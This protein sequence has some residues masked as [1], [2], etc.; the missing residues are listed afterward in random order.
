MTT[1]NALNVDALQ[2]DFDAT[3]DHEQRVEP[4]DW[5]PDGYRKTLIRQIAQHAHSE[6]IGMQPEGNWLTRAPSLRRKAI[7]MAKVQDEA[8]HGLYLYSAAETLGA[9]R[10]DL[11]VK[12]IEGK[13]K[14]S[15]IFNYPTLTYAD[16][17]TIGWLVDG[18]AICN[19]VPLCRSS[20]GPYA[21]A[22]IRVCKE[23]SFHQRQGYELLST[24]MRGTD[25]QRAMVQESVN[26]W[27]WPALM[28]FGP[29]DDESPNTEQSMKWGIKRHTNDELRQRFVDMSIPQA[30]ALGVTFPDPDL[31]WNEERKSHDFGEPDWSEFMQVIKGN[32]ASNIER[33]ANRR[34]A[35]ENGAWVRDAA[36]AFAARNAS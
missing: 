24:M 23:E 7:L 13:Q 17:G 18:A 34:A 30:E 2:E 19:Q 32:G 29:P 3:I 5:M 11:T 15:S 16:V 20:F 36:T 4:R 9:D 8:G 31:K 6:I 14:Y 10:A 26:R 33:I 25:E 21:R 35:H 28:M 12:L 22:M 27:W 1:S